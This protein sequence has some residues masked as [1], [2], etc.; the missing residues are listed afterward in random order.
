MSERECYQPWT[1][2]TCGVSDVVTHLASEDARTVMDDAVEQ[3]AI[4]KPQCTGK[5]RF[6]D[7]SRAAR[8]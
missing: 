6:S 3:H 1:C 8:A 7:L 5:P 2:D 4:A